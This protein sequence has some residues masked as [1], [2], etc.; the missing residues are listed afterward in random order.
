MYA[1]RDQRLAKHA[2][3]LLEIDNELMRMLPSSDATLL[4]AAYVD[5][6]LVQLELLFS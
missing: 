1:A 3:N 6:V 2:E 4:W 5:R